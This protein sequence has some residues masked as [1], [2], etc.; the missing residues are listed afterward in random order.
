LIHFY[1]REIKIPSKC[2][3]STGTSCDRPVR[4]IKMTKRSSRTSKSFGPKVL[5][6]GAQQ[7]MKKQRGVPA[8]ENPPS[9]R[10]SEDPPRRGT[11]TSDHPP[12]PATRASNRQRYQRLSIAKNNV[13]R[14]SS[15][16]ENDGCKG[17]LSI[18]KGVQLV[19]GEDS[20]KRKVLSP[21]SPQQSNSVEN[22]TNEGPKKSVRKKKESVCQGRGSNSEVKSPS[23][24][25]VLLV[26]SL[27]L[28]DNSQRPPRVFERGDVLGAGGFAKVYSVTER[29]TGI[30]YADKVI[31][32]DILK[33]RRNAREK[34]ER[35]IIIH[36]KMS[37]VN[38][39]KFHHYFEDCTFIH[40]ILELA[41]RDTLFHVSRI[42]GRVTEPEVK[43]YFCQIAAGTKY[44]H[45]QKILHRDLKLGNMFLSAN[46]IVKIGDFGLSST[47]AENT[48]SVCGTP[49]YVAPEIISKE[50]H[51]VESEIWSIGCIVYALLCGKPPFESETKAKT[52]ELISA[53]NYQ[54]PS[55]LSCNGVNFLSAILSADPK[56]RGNLKPGADG[57]LL[58]HPFILEGFI[59]DRLPVS[60]VSEPPKFTENIPIPINVESKVDDSQESPGC[61]PKFSPSSLSFSLKRMKGF[62]N[63]KNEFLL[64]VSTQLSI[65]L[66]R[67]DD[68]ESPSVQTREVPVPVFVSKWVDYS[69]QFGFIFQ[70]SDGSVGVVFNDA[71]KMGIS[72]CRRYLEFTDVKGK[73]SKCLVDENSNIQ[74]QNLDDMK[75]RYFKLRSYIRYMEE[76]LSDTNLRGQEIKRI[77]I[78]QKTLIPQMKNW[79][80]SEDCIGMELSCS[81]VQVNFLEDH[82][83]I[84]I[85]APP[86]HPD[87]MISSICSVGSKTRVESLSLQSL[88]SLLTARPRSVLGRLEAKVRD[89]LQ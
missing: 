46:M 28:V 85:W 66:R 38:I 30:R 19:A 50:G 80:R 29:S 27:V 32:T 23:H 17:L 12:R 59:P 8:S 44:I 72:N 36:E 34:V 53:V 83:K 63:S 58:S 11:R 43:Y 26:P 14:L 25:T 61:S 4:T 3:Q 40:L 1:K 39:V 69:E 52:F 9:T 68:A 22:P 35:E 84:I 51:S 24:E 5:T 57:S 88:P 62:F 48:P 76:M 6:E 65:F 7:T 54:I 2:Q 70:L 31:N 60:A 77:V 33:K 78:G 16:A 41:P 49:N 87:L 55:H 64:Q 10:A 79:D 71:S 75:H 15:E 67:E 74:S 89:L 21:Q 45:D 56:S 18:N 86:D 37:H 20:S 47:F 73:V 81:T 13:L 82:I 42:R